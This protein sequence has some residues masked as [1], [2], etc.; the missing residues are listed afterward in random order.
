[1]YWCTTRILQDI[2][3]SAE[4][5]FYMTRLDWFE[6]LTQSVWNFCIEVDTWNNIE[7]CTFIEENGVKRKPCK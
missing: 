6:D 2:G 5:D 3:Y 7:S 4:Q 1:M